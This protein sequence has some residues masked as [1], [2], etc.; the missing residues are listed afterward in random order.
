MKLTAVFLLASAVGAIA[1]PAENG[2][3]KYRWPVMF[4]AV[5]EH[6]FEATVRVVLDGRLAVE[7]A[8]ADGSDLSAWVTE[9]FAAWFGVRPKV[10]FAGGDVASV[11]KGDEAYAIDARPGTLRIAAR[12]AAGVRWALMTLRQLA[13]PTRGT[14]TV[15]T[16]E[17]PAL[18]IADAPETPFRAVHL[19]A[20]PE[21]SLARIERGIRM[22]AYYK[23]NHV[24]LESWGTYRS[25]ALPWYGWKDG[26]LTPEACR[27]L[28]A[29]ARDLGVEII[30]FFNVF[31]HASAAR[32]KAG[33]HAALDVSPVRQ[34]MFEPSYGYNWCL[35]NPYVLTAQRAI[36]AELHEAFGR[37]SYFH[38]GGD[39]AD[40]PTCAA[41]HAADYGRMLAAHMKALIAHVKGLGAR[42]MIWHDMLVKEGDPRWKG[43]YAHGTDAT[44]SLLD[45]LP[46]DVIICDWFYEKPPQGDR[47]PTLDLFREKG[48]ETMTCPWDDAAG[49]KAQCAYARRHGLGVIMTTWNRFIARS[50]CETYTTGASCAWSGAA[51]V[52]L[53]HANDAMYTMQRD[54][55]GT[56]WRQI[57]W[58]TPGIDDYADYGF[59]PDQVGTTIG[60]Q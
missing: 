29:V 35:S 41:C 18:R 56:H 34:T 49:T 60:N 38:L 3:W 51:A 11:P 52:A 53:E 28:T 9:K 57:G 22:A 10:S 14:E 45:E 17:I 55:F 24:I 19:C 6:S 26:Y 8:C 4:P 1:A 36:I 27:H 40:P 32:G 43:F 54:I 37:P 15:A 50:I 33:K 25:A 59:F 16:Y 12:T 58:D 42:P 39:E 23:F 44:V 20:F 48:F 46:K 2:G 7:I 13:Q 30:P 47:F 5:N 21:V 31:G